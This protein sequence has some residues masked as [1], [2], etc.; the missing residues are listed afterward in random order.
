MFIADRVVITR[1][2]CFLFQE[3]GALKIDNLH[4][5]KFKKDS[6]NSLSQSFHGI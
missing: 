6:N 4:H 1:K 2:Q 5:V 3:V